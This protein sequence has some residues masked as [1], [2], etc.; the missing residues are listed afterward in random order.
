MVGG[1]RM[2]IEFASSAPG[3][4]DAD[5]RPKLL[6]KFVTFLLHIRSLTHIFRVHYLH[7]SLVLSAVVLVIVTSISLLTPPIPRKHV[8]I[9]VYR[10]GVN[11]GPKDQ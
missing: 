7:F 11:I 3:C 6:S 5:D 2:F 4:G 1:V 10:L 8:R 9:I